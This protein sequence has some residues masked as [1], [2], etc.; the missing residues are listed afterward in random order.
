LLTLVS[1]AAAATPVSL[2]ERSSHSRMPTSTPP[3]RVWPCR[4]ASC[5]VEGRLML[6]AC[7]GPPTTTRSAPAALGIVRTSAIVTSAWR[8]KPSAMARAMASVLPNIDS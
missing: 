7:V 5:R 2:G 1:N 4:S 8:A 3:G 6:N